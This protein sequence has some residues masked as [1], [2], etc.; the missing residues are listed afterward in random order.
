MTARVSAVDAGLLPGRSWPRRRSSGQAAKG[1]LE[2]FA[3]SVVGELP[4]H[5][6][7]G[8]RI[9]R[10]W[11]WFSVSYSALILDWLLYVVV[12]PVLLAVVLWRARMAQRLGLVLS[13][14]VGGY[15]AWAACG[16]LAVKNWR[17][18]T[19]FPTLMFMDWMQ[20]IT[21]VHAFGRACRQ[22]TS[23]CKWESPARQ[24]TRMEMQ[25]AH[26]LAESYLSRACP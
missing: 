16:A 7:A 26:P 23:E 20:R 5:R 21:F 11:S 6:P 18:V 24:D 3:V 8:H 1:R 17:L 25:R 19:M 13:I 14:Y 15:V 12:W 22:P 4:D 9:G 2:Q 10:R